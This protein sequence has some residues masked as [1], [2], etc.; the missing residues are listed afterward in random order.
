MGT[1]EV[2]E[3]ATLEKEGAGVQHRWNY[4]LHRRS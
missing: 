3:I 4:Q 1:G 2:P